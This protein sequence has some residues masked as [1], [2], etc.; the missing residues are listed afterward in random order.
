MKTYV[1]PSIVDCGKSEE[2]IKGKCGW[3]KEM[4][5]FDKT[6]GY[7]GTRRMKYQQGQILWACGKETVCCPQ[8][9]EC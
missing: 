9:N 2:V 5:G 7:W 3:G 1:K 4:P 8:E 6:G